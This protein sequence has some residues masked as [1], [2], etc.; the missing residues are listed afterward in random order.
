MGAVAAF[1]DGFDIHSLMWRMQVTQ[2]RILEHY[3]QEVVARQT[4]NK[5]PEIARSRIRAASRLYL[6]LLNP[7]T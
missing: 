5:M 3:L 7:Q 6:A 2:Q 4:L 1:T